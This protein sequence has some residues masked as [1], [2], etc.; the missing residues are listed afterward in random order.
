MT[1]PRIVVVN[2]QAANIHSVA[3][4]LERMGA[5]VQ[6][7]VDVQA[8]AAADGAVLPGVGA[9]DAAMRALSG[10]AL[11]EPLREFARS[12]RPLLCVCLGMQ[13]LFPCSE[14]G[15]LP[16]LGLLDGQVRRFQ[17]DMPADY[18]DGRLKVPHM[19]WNEVTFTGGKGERHP[20]FEGIDQGE[21]FYFVHSYYCAP[22]HPAAVAATARYGVGF[23]A[24]VAQGEIVG[25][26][27]HPEKSG[28]LGLRIY[29]NFTRHVAERA[30]S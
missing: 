11:A 29:E 21:H 22:S 3:K 16:G 8:L 19:G 26:Q 17:V 9:S 20:V 2:H 10:L 30:A 5:D 6:V 13:L 7:T 27:F 15:S 1:G 25:T 18:G 14:E 24:A 28:S 23:C 4:A 12:G